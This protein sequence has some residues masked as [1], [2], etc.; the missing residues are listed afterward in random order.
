[1]S[2]KIFLMPTADDLYVCLNL[3]IL[4]QEINCLAI[5]MGARA[6]KQLK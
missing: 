4:T 2:A 1:M 3:R 5:A 6:E